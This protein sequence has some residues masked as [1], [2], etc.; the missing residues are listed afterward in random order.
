MRL[1]SSRNLVAAS[2]AARGRQLHEITVQITI[3]PRRHG[4]RRHPAFAR[5]RAL[6]PYVADALQRWRFEP[7]GEPRRQRMQLV[8]SH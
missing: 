5:L 4:R 7:P 8:F 3:Q 1:S 2:S 6:Q